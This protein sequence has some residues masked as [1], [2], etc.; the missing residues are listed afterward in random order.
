MT[1]PVIAIDRLKSNRASQ[2]VLQL[3][4]LYKDGTTH[5]VID[6]LEFMEHQ[7]ALVPRPHLHLIRPTR[8]CAVKS[9]PLRQSAPQFL[10][11]PAVLDRF[12]AL[13]I[14]LRSEKRWLKNSYP[15]QADRGIVLCRAD[16]RPVRLDPAQLPPGFVGSVRDRDRELAALHAVRGRSAVA[17]ET[18]H[19]RSDLHVRNDRV[20]AGAVYV[21]LRGTSQRSAVTAP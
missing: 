8:S 10:L 21:R 15:Y 18:K 7:A 2:V 4:S 20:C 3:K 14:Y 1:R 13:A 11:N 17:L 6:P 19:D 16:H 5:I 9:F 12:G